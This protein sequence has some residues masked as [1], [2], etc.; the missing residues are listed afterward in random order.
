MQAVPQNTQLEIEPAALDQLMPMHVLVSECG[1]IAAAGP[2]LMKVFAGKPV[3]EQPFFTLFEVS[4]PGG[5]HRLD[6]LRRNRGARLSLI[7]KGEIPQPLRGVVQSAAGCRHL[8][9]NL[10]F[11]ISVIDAVAAFSLTDADF[12][13]TDLAMELLYLV[14]A[15]TAVMQELRQLN[16]RLQGAHDLA[17]QQAQTDTLTGL[18]NRRR[19]A[20]VLEET[21]LQ[22]QEFGL[23]HIDLDYFK[24]VN[25]SLG[26]AAGDYVLCQVGQ[27]LIDET[28]RADTVARVGG[29]EFVL[30]LPE[31]ADPAVLTSVAARIVERLSEPI[32]F[33]GRTCAISASIGIV[34]ST[35][36]HP[37]QAAKMLADAD[38][39]LYDS[40]NTGRGQAKLFT[41]G[42]SPARPSP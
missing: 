9:L 7:A 8:L 27:R 14:E 1:T 23:M 26:H 5:I 29:D 39:A 35:G 30:L 36:Y 6:D 20:R 2:T 19:L 24:A 11:G 40:K 17:Q 41:H 13:V 33:E 15:K 21:I 42:L 4:R 31:L 16:M 3:L 12:A 34:T 38:S 32:V 25:D 18:S 22:S 10:S 28:R 37:P